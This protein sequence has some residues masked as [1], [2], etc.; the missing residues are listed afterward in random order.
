MK[1]HGGD[2]TLRLERCAHC[3]KSQFTEPFPD[4]AIAADRAIHR[5]GFE[6]PIPPAPGPRPRCRARCSGPRP[7]NSLPIALIYVAHQMGR[8]MDDFPSSLAL[9]GAGLL[10]VLILA[11][12]PALDGASL[13][14][15]AAVPALMAVWAGVVV[16]IDR[17]VAGPR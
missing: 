10:A 3:D 14:E 11:L 2:R 8:S 15:A 9:W 5:P 6:P 4:T 16:L 1:Q 7:L 17:W 12:G 13:K